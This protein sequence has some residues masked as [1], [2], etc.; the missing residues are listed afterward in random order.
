M[1]ERLMAFGDSLLAAHR[2]FLARHRLPLSFFCPRSTPRDAKSGN[3][4][5]PD[6]QRSPST[7][8]TS[9]IFI[10]LWRYRQFSRDRLARRSAVK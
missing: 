3:A 8:K 1:N 9:T 4:G 5:R 10:A 2:K 6:S 7:Y